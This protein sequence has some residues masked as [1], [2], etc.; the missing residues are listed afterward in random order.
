MLT[1]LSRMARS[2]QLEPSRGMAFVASHWRKVWW[3]GLIVI[4]LVAWL[5][6]SILFRLA[7]Q[8]SEDSNF[9]HGFLVPVF[10]AFVLWRDRSR[11]LSLPLRPCS[12]GLL[13]VALGL[14]LLVM[15]VLGA[16]LFLARVSFLF[17]IAGLVVAFLGVEH[18]RAA[19]FPLSFLFLMIPIPAIIFNQITF[20]LE[21]VASKVA[22]GALPW[23]GIPVLR[24][25]NIIVLPRMSLQ[26]AEACS[27][28]RSLLSLITLAVIFGYLVSGKKW[29]RVALVLAALPIA[30]AANSL[31][32]IV[33]GLLVQYWSP[34]KAVG[35][36]HIFSGWL[37][38]LV[39]VVMLCSLHQLLVWRH[40]DRRRSLALQL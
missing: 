13:A 7:L 29:V 22:A 14:T 16:E 27:G 26:V 32:I 34:D 39:S 1:W 30:I 31:R 36:F 28:I 19:I 23:L 18:L 12:W 5:Y 6:S 24:E 40:L 3:Q 2:T 10:S 38:F 33:T 37:V 17:L 4:L 11:L 8:W 35:F 20:P 15:G 25:G 21:I 9:S